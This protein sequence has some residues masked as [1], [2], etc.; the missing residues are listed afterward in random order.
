M[1]RPDYTKSINACAAHYGDEADAVRRYMVE[2][3]EKA[4]ALGNRGPIRFNA[5]GS[6]DPGIAEAY[7]KHGFYVFENVIGGA[8]MADILEDI[9]DVRSRFPIHPGSSVDTQG[10]PAIGAGCKGPGLIWSKPLTDPLGGTDV[11]NGRHQVKLKDLKAAADAPEEAPFV[12]FGSLQ[13][14]D[15]ALRVY[16]HPDL[17]RVAA[18]INGEDFAPFNEVLFIK[19]AGLGSAVSW[20]QDGDT[21]WDNPAFD[22]GIHG[23]NF[24]A[25]VYGSTP[26]NGVW[27]VP[28]THKMGKID[29]VAMVEESG[30]ER[31]K[32]AVPI[33]CEPGDVVMCNRQLVHGS[34]A[35]S[36]FE[37][38][39]TINFGFHRR[40]SVL[41]VKGAG[42]HSPVAVYTDEIIQQRSKALGYAIAARHNQYPDEKQYDYKPFRD[43][44]ATFVW[45]S[46][47]R[48][49]MRDYNLLDLSI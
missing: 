37:P 10:R 6:L 40:S 39:L 44:G 42:I 48:A 25:Q 4:Y 26:V 1:A 14:S 31:L 13:F 35:N 36:G 16:G 43:T 2:G 27:V 30:S 18:A 11:S 3:Q 5:D 33:V 8:E 9:E 28:G 45:D 29:I 49:D 47:A 22:E 19:D 41:D 15:A 24:M 38:R 21:H 7:S 20:H 23:F 34:F 17:L 46:A 32:D 12:L